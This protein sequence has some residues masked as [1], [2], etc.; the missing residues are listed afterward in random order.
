[1][2]GPDERPNR[3]AC[4]LPEYITHDLEQH[5]VDVLVGMCDS[6]DDLTEGNQPLRGAEISIMPRDQVFVP[7]R[8]T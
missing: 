1:M 7:V 3:L 5:R 4:V 6:G 2:I 8:L